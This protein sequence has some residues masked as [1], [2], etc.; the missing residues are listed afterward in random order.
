[1]IHNGHIQKVYTL[2]FG[3]GQIQDQLTLS[4]LIYFHGEP[5]LG[6]CHIEYSFGIEDNNF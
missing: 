5:N 4:I 1:M 2:H 3:V 6:M